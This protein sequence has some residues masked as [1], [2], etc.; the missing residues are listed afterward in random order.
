MSFGTK[1]YTIRDVFRA[2][3]FL[4]LYCEYMMRVAGNKFYFLVQKNK[5]GILWRDHNMIHGTK[6]RMD[7]YQALKKL[8]FHVKENKVRLS[9]SFSTSS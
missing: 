9:L 7:F 3:F 4:L 1:R 8:N 6:I 2:V 5:S